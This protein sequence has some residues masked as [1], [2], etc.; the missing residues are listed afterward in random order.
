MAPVELKTELFL[1]DPSFKNTVLKTIQDRKIAVIHTDRIHWQGKNIPIPTMKAVVSWLNQN[2][3]VTIGIGTATRPEATDAPIGGSQEEATPFGHRRSSSAPQLLRLPART[4]VRAADGAAAASSTQ[5]L[6]AQT[7]RSG[8]VVLARVTSARRVQAAAETRAA[9]PAQSLP[10]PL[11]AQSG[12]ASHSCY[13][14]RYHSVACG[15]VRTR[16]VS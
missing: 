2:D 6:R 13:G 10:V 8:V 14:R 15:G 16:R 11:A 7:N 5:A 3:F 1:S 4:H 9:P 12:P